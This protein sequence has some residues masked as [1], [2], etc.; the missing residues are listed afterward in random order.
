MKYHMKAGN[1]ALQLQCSEKL[2]HINKIL[3]SY[4]CISNDLVN[5]KTSTTSLNFDCLATTRGPLIK[6]APQEAA[7]NFVSQGSP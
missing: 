1:F 3:F 6:T 5:R 7:Q 2:L 4:I